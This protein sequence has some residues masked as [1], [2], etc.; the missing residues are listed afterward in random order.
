MWSDIIYNG[1]NISFPFLNLNY[2]RLNSW[3]Y[4]ADFV[5]DTHAATVVAFSTTRGVS[6]WHILFD[7]LGDFAARLRAADSMCD[8]RFLKVLRRRDSTFVVD[9]EFE[10]IVQQFTEF[11][12][13]MWSKKGD[14]IHNNVVGGS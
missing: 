11:V 5:F 8:M 6:P 4:A 1:D 13:S 7:A 3:T 14:D 9:R 2:L 10:I 12:K